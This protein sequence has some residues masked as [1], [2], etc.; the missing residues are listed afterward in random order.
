MDEPVATHCYDDIIL[1]GHKLTVDHLVG[2]TRMLRLLQRHVDMRL[3][4]HTNDLLPVLSSCPS[5]SEG[6]QQ[7]EGIARLRI[8]LISVD[9]ILE[10]P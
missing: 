10:R 7:D 8:A 2:V 9:F 4:E 6:V 3:L 1:P 5:S